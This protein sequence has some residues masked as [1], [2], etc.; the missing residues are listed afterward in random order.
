MY[1]PSAPLYLYQAFA[2][3]AEVSSLRLNIALKADSN[4][5]RWVFLGSNTLQASCI[6]LAL[7]EFHGKFILGLV[8]GNRSRVLSREAGTA[9]STV[10]HKGA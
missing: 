1:D 10:T 2:G 8:L 7:G 3:S 9:I 5:T 6:S 4:I